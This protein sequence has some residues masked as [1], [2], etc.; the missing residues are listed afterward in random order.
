M[1]LLASATLAGCSSGSSTGSA[2][3]TSG[4]QPGIYA[5]GAASQAHY[6]VVLHDAGQGTVVG[7]ISYLAHGSATTVSTFTGWTQSKVAI[8]TTASGSTL[9]V[10]FSANAL[11]LGSCTSYL[12]LATGKSACIFHLHHAAPEG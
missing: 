2:S 11:D 3:A 12:P 9:T 8:L 6:V 10:P 4:L 7:A 1:V 5:D